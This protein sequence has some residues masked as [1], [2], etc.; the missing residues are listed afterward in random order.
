MVDR[1]E[2]SVVCSFRLRRLLSFCVLGFAAK[3]FAV[4]Y[5]VPKDRFEIERSGAIIIGHVLSSHV[6]STPRIG[7]ETV[8]DVVVEE[9]IKGDAG[10]VIHIREPGGMLANDAL[11][12]PGVPE[13]IEGERVLLFLD[14]RENGDYVVNDLQLGS[15]HFARDVTGQSVV[16]R[17]EGELSGWDPDGTVH[18]EPHRLAE[19]FI[20]YVRG[21]ARGDP[22][23]EDYVIPRAPLV[24]P[25][26]LIEQA[27]FSAS[28]YTVAFGGGVGAR[29]NVFRAP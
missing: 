4:S 6:E 13:F 21:V 5:V 12:I 2:V 15:F 11:I 17:S 26:H 1:I 27:A 24:A 16:L 7:I 8:T 10:G 3:T 18:K 25:P 14:Q 29:W 20:R 23:A 22:V 19:R 9:A 28:S